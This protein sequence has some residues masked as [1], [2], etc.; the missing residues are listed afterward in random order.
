M[1]TGAGGIEL[2]V[3]DVEGVLTDGGLWCAEDGTHMKR[4]AIR[5]G[6]GI[7]LLLSAGVKVAVLSGHPSPVTEARMRALGVTDV[8]TGV[9]RKGE[10]FEQILE[11]HGVPAE[12][13][14]AMGDDLNDL[15]MMRRAGL[16]VTVA[17][18]PPE[19]QERAAYVTRNPGGHGAV[20]ELAEH[21]LRAR[22]ELERAI[23]R[24]A[25]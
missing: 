14:A 8:R 25:E 22:G 10:S 19:V 5:D 23:R 9:E 6:L 11:R 16:A 24:I 21:V 20:R 7:K 17:D 12:R 13:A 2:V 1:G 4:F 18:A 3:L 15:P